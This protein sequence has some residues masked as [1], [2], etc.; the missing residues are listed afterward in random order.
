MSKKK[1]KPNQTEVWASYEDELPFEKQSFTPLSLDEIEEEASLDGRINDETVPLGQILIGEYEELLVIDDAHNSEVLIE[2]NPAL[3]IDI[4]HMA[5]DELPFEKQTFMPI[6]LD[7][8][9]EIISDVDA[10]GDSSA[11]NLATLRTQ[12][13]AKISQ[14]NEEGKIETDNKEKDN[15]HEQTGQQRNQ[16]SRKKQSDGKQTTD[17]TN[18]KPR[19]KS[20]EKIDNINK[21]ITGKQS[22]RRG[23]VSQRICISRS[24]TR[25]HQARRQK[26]VRRGSGLIT[27]RLGLCRS[28]VR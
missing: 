5:E 12:I 24:C 13:L 23:F 14:A 9:T 18:E 11:E 2:D 21:T 15:N 25:Y 17:R 19:A 27:Y 16:P 3:M 28:T 7:D 6:S 26:F 8:L 22:F 10:K 20:T 1:S 4:G